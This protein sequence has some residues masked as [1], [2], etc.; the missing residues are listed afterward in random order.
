MYQSGNLNLN[1]LFSLET[2]TQYFGRN[3]FLRFFIKELL[4]FE[5]E[6]L[7]LHK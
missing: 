1:H 4:I 2:L 5:N 6:P 7:F 3:Y